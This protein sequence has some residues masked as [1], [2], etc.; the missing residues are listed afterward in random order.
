MKIFGDCDSKIEDHEAE[1]AN[2]YRKLTSLQLGE[3]TPDQ[4]A[5]RVTKNIEGATDNGN[6]DADVELCYDTLTCSRKDRRGESAA[7][8]GVGKDGADSK[9]AEP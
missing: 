8:T 7:E 9:P 6:F 3:R 1:H 2:K 5:E 4:R